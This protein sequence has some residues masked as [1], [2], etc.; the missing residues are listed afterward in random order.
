MSNRTV[1]I[2]GK[3]YGT[4]PCT[5]NATFNGNVVYTGA[6]PTT[7][8]PPII[9]TPLPTEV[10]FTF[11]IPMNLLGTFPMNI[12]FTGDN[13]FVREV[14]ANYGL[15]FN[16]IYNA[17]ESAVLM[18]LVVPPPP[19]APPHTEQV[20]IYSSKATPPF[21]AE[22]LAFLESADLNTQGDLFRDTLVAHACEFKQSFGP[23]TFTEISP[24]QSKINV[25]INGVNYTTPESPTG[26]LTGEWGYD[27]PSI[28]GSGTITFDLIVKAGLE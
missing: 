1:Q 25:S 7:N 18:E 17:E 15:T 13:I 12:T 4:T 16:P 14:L 21:T 27:V 28:D 8:E 19:P 20:A 23:T 9:T 6:I 10:L 5:V 24:A 22:E 26:D 3:A 2:L 11:E